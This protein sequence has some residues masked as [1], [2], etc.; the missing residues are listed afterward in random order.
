MGLSGSMKIKI[1][2]PDD[3]AE[4]SVIL[5]QII[6]DW[7][8]DRPSDAGHVR[9]FYVEHKDTIRT[10]VAVGE[11]NEILGFQHLRLATN[12]NVYGVT[13]GWGIVGTYVKLD[14][15][16]Q[17][18]GSALFH[19]TLSAA[20]AANLQKIDATIAKTNQ[21]GLKYYGALGFETYRTSLGSLSKA[22]SVT[23]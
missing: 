1:A 8:S 3:A 14:A 7:G 16:R 2:T 23:N 21:S 5:A 12:D 20:R 17:G 11:D 19:A 4:M 22:F 6:A 15:G 10:H 13:P 9:T 18:I